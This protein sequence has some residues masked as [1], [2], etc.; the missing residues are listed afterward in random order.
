M[1]SAQWAGLQRDVSVFLPRVALFLARQNLQVS[2]DPHARGGRLDDVINKPCARVET[3]SVCHIQ[4]ACTLH[5]AVGPVPICT[6][7]H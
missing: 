5:K 1:C 7:P 3:V 2:A 4:C 6:L